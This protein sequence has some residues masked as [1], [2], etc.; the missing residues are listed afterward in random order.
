[1]NNVK[2]LIILIFFNCSSQKDDKENCILGEKL[3]IS[4]TK[5]YNPVCGCNGVTYSNDCVAKSF[6]IE[7]WT[8]GKC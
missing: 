5:E 4:C 7:N 6:G 3:N 8:S 1:M 2:F